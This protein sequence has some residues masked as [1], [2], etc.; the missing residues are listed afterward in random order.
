MAITKQIHSDL[1]WLVPVKVPAIGQI[2]L[3]KI[4]LYPIGPCAKKKNS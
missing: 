1:E 4:F 3:L 2:D